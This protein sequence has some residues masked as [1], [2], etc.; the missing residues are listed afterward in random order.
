MEKIT[1]KKTINTPINRIS[2]NADDADD[3]DDVD[4][5]DDADGADD[6]DGADDADDVFDAGNLSRHGRRGGKGKGRKPADRR[7][8]KDKTDDDE[9][10]GISLGIKIAKSGGAAGGRK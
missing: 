1:I 4:D 8:N 3:A 10:I 5:A 9:V 7:P 2:D 6:T